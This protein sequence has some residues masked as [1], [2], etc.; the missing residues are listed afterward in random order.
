M[1]R[2]VRHMGAAA[3]R[4]RGG[5][6][7]HGCSC[8]DRAGEREREGEPRRSTQTQPGAVATRADGP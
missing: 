4:R 6:L 3:E 5:N 7:R 8:R 2:E 1:R